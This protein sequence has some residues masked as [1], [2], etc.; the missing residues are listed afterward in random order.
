MRKKELINQTNKQTNKQT[1]NQTKIEGKERTNEQTDR[2]I[3]KVKEVCGLCDSPVFVWKL[4]TDI[5]LIL[6]S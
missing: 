3:R 4:R 1:I 5:V 2:T 6:I